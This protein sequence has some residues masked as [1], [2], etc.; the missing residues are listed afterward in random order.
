MLIGDVYWVML[1]YN[2]KIVSGSNCIAVLFKLAKRKCVDFCSHFH[3]SGDRSASWP[4]FSHRTRSATMRMINTVSLSGVIRCPVQVRILSLENLTLDVWKPM[5]YAI[6]NPF[7]IVLQSCVDSNLVIPL[8]FYL[9]MIRQP[10]SR[11]KRSNIPVINFYQ[12]CV[13][14]C[15]CVSK[16]IY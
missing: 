9:P 14:V 15:V 11:L 1:W 5:K 4:N 13:C 8:S 10:G 16:N 7:M 3:V 2:N 6:I 12:V